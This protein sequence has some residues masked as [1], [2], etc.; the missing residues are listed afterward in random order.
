LPLT[1]IEAFSVHKPVIATN[2]DGT[3]EIVLNKFNGLLVEPQN[4]SQ[5]AEAI[6]KILSNMNIYETYAENAYK[7]YL[8]KFSIVCFERNYL[9]K[10]IFYINEKKLEQHG[11]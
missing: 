5:L 1:P 2:V 3:P 8:E 7:T 10:Y 4:V 9:S 11:G 6:K